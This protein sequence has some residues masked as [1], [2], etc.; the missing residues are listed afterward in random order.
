MIGNFDPNY[1]DFLFFFPATKHRTGQDVTTDSVE[2][3]LEN[4]FSPETEKEMEK[5]SD[6]VFKS[7]E[8]SIQEQ[9]NDS[10]IKAETSDNE[11]E[12]CEPKDESEDENEMENS[13]EKNSSIQQKPCRKVPF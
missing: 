8:N 12:D 6:H 11:I 1:I 7:E 2:N 13:K 5:L 4:S 9:E 3:S 10:L